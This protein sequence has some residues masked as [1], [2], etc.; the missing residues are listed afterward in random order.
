MQ[1]WQTQEAASRYAACTWPEGEKREGK[2]IKEAKSNAK[3]NG[4]SE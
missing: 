4:T 3:I 1:C 2:G